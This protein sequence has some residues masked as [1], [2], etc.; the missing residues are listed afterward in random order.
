MTSL[1]AELN[2]FCEFSKRTKE[3]LSDTK[4]CFDDINEAGNSELGKVLFWF[5]HDKLAIQ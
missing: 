1:S 5:L 3:I 2:R 4:R